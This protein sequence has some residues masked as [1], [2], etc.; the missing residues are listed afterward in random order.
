[1]AIKKDKQSGKWIATVGSGSRKNQS[2]RKF[3]FKEDAEEW[4]EEQKLS[5]KYQHRLRPNALVE[6]LNLVDL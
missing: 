3:L 1:M 5:L 4:V 2:R 6:E